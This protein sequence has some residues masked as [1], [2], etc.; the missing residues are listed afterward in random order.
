M[1]A[2]VTTSPAAAS[3]GFAIPDRS[4]LVS[5]RYLSQTDVPWT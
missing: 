5:F 3:A 2:D 4:S 1:S